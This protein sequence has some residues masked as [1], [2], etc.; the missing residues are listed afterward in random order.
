MQKHEGGIASICSFVLPN[1]HSSLLYLAVLF[2]TIEKAIPGK[3][4]SETLCQNPR[5]EDTQLHFCTWTRGSCHPA[6]SGNPGLAALPGGTGSFQVIRTGCCSPVHPGKESWSLNCPGSPILP[7]A[8]PW[9]LWQFGD[10]TGIQ[11]A[12]RGGQSN[13]GQAV[14]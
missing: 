1:P 4:N 3:S 6:G 2:I 8:V 10:S 14:L 11:G 13:P 5:R 12:A 7:P 9:E